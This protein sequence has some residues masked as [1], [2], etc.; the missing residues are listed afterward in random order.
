LESCEVGYKI[1]WNDILDAGEFRININR[2]EEA[3][4]ILA[5]GATAGAAQAL[6]PIEGEFGSLIDSTSLQTKAM[7]QTEKRKDKWQKSSVEIDG[8]NI[9]ISK[10]LKMGNADAEIKLS[11][12]YRT[13]HPVF[14][15]ISAGL[16]IRSQA[17][18]DPGETYTLLVVPKTTPGP[19]TVTVI[20]K[21]MREY[22]GDKI[23]SIKL[24][25][26]PDRAKWRLS[27]PGKGTEESMEKKSEIVTLTQFIQKRFH[28]RLGK[29]TVW[30]SDDELRLPFDATIELAPFGEIS[31]ELVDYKKKTTTPN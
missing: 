18:S 22:Q 30:I 6:L 31:I 4:E 1:S 7:E 3:I 26:K 19:F 16:F 14:D 15:L 20:G 11:P 21:E 28:G 5:T 8:S 2:T 9:R 12:L 10:S 17:L 23:R 13:V 29:C 24:E 25:I 27:E